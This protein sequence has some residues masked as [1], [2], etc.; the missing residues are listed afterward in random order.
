MQN[1]L[2]IY[3]EE[4]IIKYAK[5]SKDKDTVK[6]E[7][8][9]LKFYDD[10][11]EA[12]EQILQETYS[13]NLPKSINISNETYN[14]F[15]T[16]SSL[17]KKDMDR[18]IKTAFE[19]YCEDNNIRINSLESRYFLVEN[20]EDPDR[21]KAVYISVPK[22]EITEK[23]RNIQSGK[24][25]TA[26][27]IAVS[28]S[29][30]LNKQMDN[31]AII[32]NLENKTDITI[33]KDG[34]VA[35]II[36]LENGI[37]KIINK[38]YD[39]LNSYS[40]AYEILKGTTLYTEIGKDLIDNVNSEYLE[41]IVP[42]LYN[43]VLEIKEVISSELVTINNVLISGMGASINNIDLYF[44]EYL[45]SST[46][47]ILKPYFVKDIPMTDISI[48][49][50]IEVNSAVCLALE[51]LGLG[52]KQINFTKGHKGNEFASREKKTK[53]KGDKNIS[54]ADLDFNFDSIEKMLLRAIISV[55][56][57]IVIYIVFLQFIY[58][59]LQDK[60]GQVENKITDID[61]QITLI[62]LDESKLKTKENNYVIKTNQLIA[63]RD[64]LTKKYKTLNKVPN[65]LTE[66]MHIIPKE[67]KLTS[68]KMPTDNIM[69]IEAESPY[70]EQ[71]GV[72]VMLLKKHK[73]S[74]GEI[75]FS[76]IKSTTVEE[77]IDKIKIKITGELN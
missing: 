21:L 35:K 23:I 40:K 7:N 37:G 26:T 10:I 5:V 53:V 68:F 6:I 29:N 25:S 59:N 30:L 50:Y 3:I 43:I 14:Y 41:Y 45:E 27:P 48:K 34:Q 17:S 54:F 57:A 69:E 49:D 52:D 38:L 67:V 46:C 24:V 28:I 56:I 22:A 47:E 76:N 51:G 71:I 42:D 55:I 44:N 65:L 60:A 2:G 8:F 74:T 77:S 19:I 62:N 4:N 32:I 39:K 73:N 61:N 64:E 36:K 12:I 20:K 70:R 11:T 1:S 66:M 13:Y 58:K 33:I 31:D 75:A 72:F 9:G 16:F 15:D 63:S 18:S